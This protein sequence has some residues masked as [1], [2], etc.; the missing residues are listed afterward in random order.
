MML[1]KLENPWKVESLYEFQYFKCPSCEFENGKKQDFLNHAYEYHP[2][3]TDYLSIITDGSLK[4]VMCPWNNTPEIDKE[5]T[6]NEDYGME[7]FKTEKVED[8]P[9][10]YE[11]SHQKDHVV[12]QMVKCYY[13]T[14]EI[15][16]SI[17]RSHMQESHPSKPVIFNIIKDAKCAPED[18]KTKIIAIIKD[19]EIN[20]EPESIMEKELDHYETNSMTMVMCFHCSTALIYSDIRKHVEEQHPGEELIYF[21]INSVKANDGIE[22]VI[23]EDQSDFNCDLCGKSFFSVDALIAHKKVH[24]SPRKKPRKQSLTS[25]VMALEQQELENEEFQ[26]KICAKTFEEVGRLKKHILNSGHNGQNDHKCDLCGKTFSTKIRL[27][28]HVMAIHEQIKPHKCHSCEKSFALKGRLRVHLDEVHGDNVYICEICSCTFSSTTGL[29]T[30]VKRFHEGDKSDMVVCPQCGKSMRNNN[31]NTHTRIVHEGIKNAKCEICGK[32]FT[33]RQKLKMHMLSVH[34]DIKDHTCEACGM[35]FSQVASLKRHIQRV[36]EKRRDFKCDQ[37]IKSFFNMV[38][39]K[40]HILKVHVDCKH[41]CETCGNLFADNSELQRHMERNHSGN[42][43]NCD[44]CGKTFP[45]EKALKAHLNNDHSAKKLSKI[46]YECISCGLLFKRKHHLSNHI[47]AVHE[48]RKD[49]KCD[50]CQKQFSM[51]NNLLQHINAV[52]KGI[53]RNRGKKDN[54]IAS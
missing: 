51:K 48:R 19:Q 26:C 38:G 4:D 21:P 40:Q 5:F 18:D 42:K 12:I 36:H 30:H 24:L 39:L 11:D 32:L 14:K 33:V 45:H 8:I 17:V 1:S 34:E 10:L 54:M 29:K 15:D 6:D 43:L 49:H 23:H 2:E 44:C 52:H 16:I 9:D 46:D 41:R 37:C 7:Y 31:L 22:S 28:Y 53:K 3:S 27:K 20:H 50:Q 47:T 13:C 35:C 25:N